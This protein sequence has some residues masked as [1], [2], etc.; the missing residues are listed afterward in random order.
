[1]QKLK[2]QIKKYGNKDVFILTARPSQSQKAIHEYLKS[3]GVDLPIENITGLGNSTG[4]AKANWMIDKLAEGYNDF[5]FVDDAMPNVKAVDDL[6]S[7]FDIKSKS[8][9]AIARNSE[10]LGRQVNEMLEVN[11][12]IGADVVVDDAEARVRGARK[13]KGI[14]ARFFTPRGGNDFL[15]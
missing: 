13:G 2:N 14:G 11:E 7:Q 4:E 12:G 1:M 15:G 9:Q 10:S 6:L 8:V 5:Y 3:E